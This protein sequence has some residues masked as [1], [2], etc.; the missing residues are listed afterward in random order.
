[1]AVGAFSLGYLVYIKDRVSLEG[2]RARLGSLIPVVE[3]K[4][5]FDEAYQWAVD[6]VVLVFANFI[7]LFDRIV[8]NDLAVNGPANSVHRLG[9]AM[10]LHVTGHVYSYAM[11]MVL[12]TIALSIFWWFRSVS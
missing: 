3:N 11:G 6:R 7:G 2:F 4:Y 1:L 8:I 5:Y 12:G 10:R 9:V